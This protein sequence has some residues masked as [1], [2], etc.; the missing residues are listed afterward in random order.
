[1]IE[2]V[3]RSDFLITEGVSIIGYW[4]A[5][6]KP[7][8]VLRDADSPTFNDDGN[9]LL[10]GIEQIE[11]AKSLFEWLKKSYT[12]EHVKTNFNLI[13]ISQTVHPTFKESPIEMMLR[14]V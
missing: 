2:D 11:D 3:M 8:V 7:L 13:E 1:M 10:S 14:N 5:T 12:E 6:G 9:K 4:A